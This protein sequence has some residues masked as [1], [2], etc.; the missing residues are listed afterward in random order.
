MEYWG[1]G[2]YWYYNTNETCKASFICNSEIGG[3]GG[4]GYYMNPSN[5]NAGGWANSY[6]Y[7]FCEGRMFNAMPTAWQSV[8][9]S[10]EIKATAGSQS[11]SIVTS[12]NKI[13]LPS[14]RELGGS[15]TGYNDDNNQ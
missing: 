1:T 15:G 2:K 4:R 6:M 11:T 8:I 3:L 5:T 12:S 10:V 9:R 13:Y 7:N 14:Y